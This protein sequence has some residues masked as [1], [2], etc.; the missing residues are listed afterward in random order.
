MKLGFS[1]RQTVA[2]IVLVA[3]AIALSA[4][5]LTQASFLQ[6]MLIVLQILSIM[7]IIVLAERVAA[8]VRLQVLERRKKPRETTPL[9]LEDVA[10][11]QAAKSPQDS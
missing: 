1:H 5:R 11:P 4:V 7:S 6:S 2:F 9:E 3:F 8:K 10:I